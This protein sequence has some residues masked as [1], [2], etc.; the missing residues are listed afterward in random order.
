MPAMRQRKTHKLGTRLQQTR[1]DRKVCRTSREWLD[2]HAPFLA[3]EAKS[4]EGALLAKPL[5]LVND[6]V[7]AIIALARIALA[8]LV[9]K[10]GAQ[11]LHHRLRGEVLARNQLN[12]LNLTLALLSYQLCHLGVNR[13]NVPVVYRECGRSCAFCLCCF[14]HLATF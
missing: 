10:A 2:V 7:P 9:R 13:G 5:N 14:N 8:V 6:L 12:T 3:I 1:I 11:S 4:L